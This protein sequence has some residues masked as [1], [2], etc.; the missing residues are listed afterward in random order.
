VRARVGILLLLGLAVVRVLLVLANHAGDPGR[1]FDDDSPSYLEP[2]RALVEDHRF[3]TEPGSETPELLRTPGYPT[4]L[5]AFLLVD[6]DPLLAVTAQAALSVLAVWLT[7][8]TARRLDLSP[9]WAAAAAAIVAVEPFQ[10]ATAGLIMTESIATSAMAA[11]AYCSVRLARSD[12]APRWAVAL[13][14]ALVTATYIRPTTLYLPPLLAGVILVVGARHR[15]VRPDSRRAAA[16][17]LA[18]TLP[19]TGLWVWRNHQQLDTWSFSAIEAV[20][21]YWY[22]A[23]GLVATRDGVPWDPDTRTAFTLRLDPTLDERTVEP[24]RAGTAVP[25][26]FEGREGEYYAQARAEA[27]DILRDDPAGVARQ[28]AR[29]TYSLLMSTGWTSAFATFGVDLPAPV[30]ALATAVN[31]LLLSFAAGGAVTELR[32]PGLRSA[33]LLVLVTAAYV[34]AVGSGYEGVAGHRF[35]SVVVPVLALYATIGARSLYDT[36]RRPRP[37]GAAAMAAGARG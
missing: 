36:W 32:R 9:G 25:P 33:H 13:G 1:L 27:I 24:Y 17:L 15:A 6:D 2:A 21:L 11:V 4:F 12:F 37:T 5:A 8:L 28:R 34:L 20:N 16:A 26:A 3:T 22:Q 19:L 10:N 30:T 14:A 18:V 31:L 35:R 29:G 23:A 7:Y